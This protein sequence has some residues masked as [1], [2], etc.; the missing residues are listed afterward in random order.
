MSLLMGIDLGTSSVKTVIMKPGGEI[1]ALD[2]EEYPILTPKEG[3]AEQEPETWW[4]ATVKT[5]KNSLEKARHKGI[6]AA[7]ITGIGFS[8][9]MHGMVLLDKTGTPLRPAIIWC[10]SRSKDQ[11]ADIYSNV[12]MK[13]LGGI[14]LNPVFPGF[15]LAS[16]LWVKE[17]EP[18]LYE[19]IEHVLLPKDYIRY[20]L[21]GEIGTDYTDAS[22]TL[23]FDTGK[24][25]WSNELLEA[26]DLSAAPYPKPG[27]PYETA[28]SVKT[29]AAEETGLN[30]GTTVVFGGADQPMQ[31]V[32]NGVIHPGVVSVTIGTGGQVLAF[33]DTPLFNPHLNTHT[34][35]HALPDSWYVMGAT[36]SA[37]L[38]LRWFR[39]HVLNGFS[40]A[41]LSKEAKTVPPGSEGIVFLPYLAGERTPHLD[42]SAKALFFGMTFRH[43][44][45]HLVRAIMEGVVFSLK[46]GFKL[47]QDLKI[48]ADQI[49]AT[50]GGAKSDL[51]LQIQADIFDRPIRKSTVKEAAATGAAMMAGIG[52]GIYRNVT[53][54]SEA[55]TRTSGKVIEPG[56]ANRDIY[57][58]QFSTF[59]EL[60]KRNKDLFAEQRH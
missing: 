27:Y 37:G 31:A 29:E 51:W 60:Y 57:E 6:K 20:R 40:F 58:K 44:R 3:Y 13:F 43:T 49:I 39:E 42:P 38:S 41:Q 7:D 28:G 18:H 54:G 16:L 24:N 1:I 22:S 50:G 59:Q 14:T 46:E 10:D 56:P 35:T 45:A 19:K 4:R 11:V 12:D 8:G 5:I 33:S 15:Q 36:L 9:Q 53:E 30:P 21:C 2:L 32:A 47:I 26:L 23:A 55:L 25:R 34:F 48:P 17:N 52:I